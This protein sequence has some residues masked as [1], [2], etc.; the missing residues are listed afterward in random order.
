[1]NMK[2]PSRRDSSDGEDGG[3]ERGVEITPVRVESRRKQVG[4]C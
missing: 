1:M 2:N 3:V 4:W